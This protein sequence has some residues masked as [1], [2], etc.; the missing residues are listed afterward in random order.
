MHDDVSAIPSNGCNVL[1]SSDSISNYNGNT[2]KDFIQNGGK[3]YL[4]RTQTTNYGSYDTSNYSCIDVE[5]INSYAVYQPFLYGL[6]FALFVFVLF[7]F[8]KT[9]KGLL[10]GI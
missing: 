10:Y 1:T 3:W 2:R 4:Y 6:G 5:S 8:I 7:F 9:I